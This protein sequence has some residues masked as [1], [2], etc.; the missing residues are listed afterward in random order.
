MVTRAMIVFQTAPSL[1]A[2]PQPDCPA[3]GP[4]VAFLNRRASIH[5]LTRMLTDATIVSRI[6]PS[7]TVGFL[8]QLT[9]LPPQVGVLT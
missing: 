3:A 6:A 9:D 8:P 7:L 2:P 5:P 4:G 1:T